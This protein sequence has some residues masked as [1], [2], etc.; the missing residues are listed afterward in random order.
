MSKSAYEPTTAV[1]FRLVI[2]LATSLFW[3]L[4]PLFGRTPYDRL[5]SF[6][7]PDSSTGVRP[8]G[9]LIEGSDGAL[10]GTTGSTNSKVFRMSKDGSGFVVLRTLAALE[11]SYPFAKLTE[12]PDGRLF[13]TTQVGGSGGGGTIFKL[14]K[15]GTDFEVLKNFGN[16]QAVDGSLPAAPV[17]FASD[18]LIYGATVYGGTNGS[19]TVFRLA[20]AGGSYTVLHN[21]GFTDGQN[22]MSGIIEDEAGLL[23]GTTAH[24]G[25]RGWGVA[26]RMN[27]DGSGFTILHSFLSGNQ[28]GGEPYAALLHGSDGV[29]Y[30]TAANGG[31]DPSGAH[32]DGIVYRL[33]TDGT[34][35]RILWSF[36]GSST[37]GEGPTSTLVEGNDGALYGTTRFGGSAGKGTVFRLNRD[38]S[39][40]TVLHQFGA[41]D[42][43]GSEPIA[44][45]VRATDG[46]FYGTTFGGGEM[47]LG[48]VFRLVPP[49]FIHNITVQSGMNSVVQCSGSSG[50]SYTIEATTG[51]GI[52]SWVQLGIRVADTNGVFEFEDTA[53]P[54][55]SIRFY[56]VVEQ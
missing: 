55:H 43:D 32:L 2:V 31:T 26:Y 15:D 14:N 40:Y 4:P 1:Q 29:L 9:A 23:Y 51:L 22:A 44:G 8:V 24:G 46:L 21:F 30:G 10:Y 49:P 13:G 41:Q 50:Q 35:Y 18:G 56:R 39:R 17:M 42:L 37:D 11:G 7:V 33:N 27:K 47:G 36:G 48:T 3:V 34:G 28:D 19:G 16:R 52:Q 20:E 53:A 25:D 5:K 54:N 6:G 45:L 38:G 12:G